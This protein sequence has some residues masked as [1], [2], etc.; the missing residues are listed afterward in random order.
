LGSTLGLPS[1]LCLD[2][3][4]FLRKYLEE[5]EHL[6]L[7]SVIISELIKTETEYLDDL[8]SVIKNIVEPLETNHH[9]Y[10][11]DSKRS[12]F[13]GKLKDI[14]YYSSKLRDAFIKNQDLF[15]VGY[16]FL[17]F[18]GEK[19]IF[20]LLKFQHPTLTSLIAL[21][22]KNLKYM[23]RFFDSIDFAFDDPKYDNFRNFLTV[24]V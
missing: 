5:K 18:V 8:K 20:F 3:A 9:S 19:K 10:L 21:Y 15:H 24:Q 13:F 12:L 2:S 22:R 17:Q 4:H 6:N 14:C 16:V 23:Y 11:S 7:K 1:E